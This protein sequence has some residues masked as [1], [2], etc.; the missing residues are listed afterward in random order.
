MEIGIINLYGI[1]N[2]LMEGPLVKTLL[3]M[4]HKVTAIVDSTRCNRFVYRS[5]G[6]Q[7][8]DYDSSKKKHF[9][10]L[11]WTH[12]KTKK[13]L[14]T[15]AN[16]WIITPAKDKS[17]KG[18]MWKFKK[19]EVEYCMDFARKLG[20]KGKVPKIT[21]PKPKKVSFTATDNTVAIGVGYY[22]GERFS[23]NKH[24]GN[25]NYVA[26]CTVL[27]GMGY[28]PVLIGDRNDCVN[29]GMHISASSPALNL[30]GRVSLGNIWSMLSDT[31]Y[32]IGNDTGLGHLAD[33][34]GKALFLFREKG[35][36][37]VKNCPWNSKRYLISPTVDEVVS[38]FK[39][40]IGG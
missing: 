30:C 8:L 17:K 20:Y 24:W 18:F 29:S 15:A 27:D 39:E 31:E 35:S 32:Y 28:L 1:G 38:E 11:V 21:L 19:H 16:E 25:S 6:I 40:M 7:T 2:A 34:Y 23:I 36:N 22:A 4:K 37:P 12:A 13:L 33:V 3:K 5:W 9:N 26:L 14:H 10:W